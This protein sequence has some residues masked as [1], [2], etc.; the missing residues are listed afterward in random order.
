MGVF[1]HDFIRYRNY[2]KDN[3]SLDLG[4]LSIG[5]LTHWQEGFAK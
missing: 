4:R 2:T 5:F 3:V 1:G